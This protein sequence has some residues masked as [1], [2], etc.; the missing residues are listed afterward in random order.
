MKNNYWEQREIIFNRQARIAE[1]K[2]ADEL[3]RV[4]A[5][6]A[7]EVEAL[8]SRITTGEN[9]IASD[10]YAY[11][12]SFQL[13]EKLKDNL[14]T[15]ANIEIKAIEKS[16]RDLYITNSQLVGDEI[17][18]NFSMNEDKIIKAIKSQWV[19]DGKIYSDRIWGNT[20]LLAER[21]QNCLV[22]ALIRGDSVDMITGQ[23][24]REFNSSWNAARR[25]VR[26]EL[27][28]IQNKSAMDMY[29]EAGYTYYE[30]F[31]AG[32]SDVCDGECEELNGKIFAMSEAQIGVNFPPIHP[33]CR[34]GILAAEKPKEI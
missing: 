23:I 15:T 5:K 30:F 10:I 4:E 9:V 13:L 8:Y 25:L 28:Y 29:E 32:D 21:V 16:M 18:Y 31:N 3:K 12:R 2:I 6:T 27:S 24:E 7:S 26:T 1:S 17:N 34:C 20:S 19:G 22:D 11:N 33:N 14:L